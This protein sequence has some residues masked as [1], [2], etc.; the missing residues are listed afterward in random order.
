MIAAAGFTIGDDNKG[1]FGGARLRF[2][3]PRPLDEE[4]SISSKATTLVNGRVGYAFDNGMKLQLDA[5]NL[6]NV[7]AEQI[8]YSYVSRLSNEVSAP[9]A[10]R[11]Y[12]P[13]EPLALRLTLS[14][15]L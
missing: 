14:G 9:P 12:H 6:L 15:R 1:W 11:H 4:R 8:A 5:L 13:V 7:K 10:D 2:F 3:G